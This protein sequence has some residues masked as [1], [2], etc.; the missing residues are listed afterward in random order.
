MERPTPAAG[1]AKATFAAKFEIK[2]NDAPRV[3]GRPA[4]ATAPPA[5][6]A[7]GRSLVAVAGGRGAARG[8]LHILQNTSALP[9][10]PP[11]VVPPPAS[12][13]QPPVW[14]MG[15]ASRERASTLLGCCRGQEAF[16]PGRSAQEALEG[17]ALG[18]A[19]EVYLNRLKQGWLGFK[20]RT[21]REFMELLRA[22]FPAAPEEVAAAAKELQQPWDASERTAKLSG[23]A[24]ENLE[25][26]ADMRGDAACTP[27]EFIHHT[28]M[29][30]CEPKQLGKD[31][32]ERKALGPPP[33]NPCRRWPR[34]LAQHLSEAVFSQRPERSGY[35][36]HNSQGRRPNGK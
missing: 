24:K 28:Y 31:C 1:I 4:H 30:A 17:F 11:A 6:E 26:L 8:R 9:G 35:F 25:R 34:P 21:L 5:R 19:G 15:Q 2:A 16:L 14:A 3:E 20:N 27:E 23:A 13:E 29:A 10:G 7:A 12:Q 32:A 33:Q 36:E 22:G 18:R